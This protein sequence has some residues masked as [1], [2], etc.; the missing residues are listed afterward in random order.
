MTTFEDMSPTAEV[1]G[2]DEVTTKM[3]KMA[4]LVRRKPA[5]PSSSPSRVTKAPAISPRV[6]VVTRPSDYEALLAR[7]GTREQARFFLET[8]GRDIREA[9]ERD[10]WQRAVL[11]AISKAIPSK[12]RRAHVTRAD[13][14]RFYFEPDDVIACVGQDGLVANVAKYLT[15]QLVIG[16]NSDP[17]RNE[18][19]L[20]PHDAKNARSLIPAALADADNM[21]IEERTMVEAITDDGLRIVALNEIFAGHRT[22]QS[23]RYRLTYARSEERQSSSGIVVSTGTGATGW[24]RSIAMSRSKAPELPKPSDPQL[25]F[26]VREAFPSIA[27]GTNLVTGSVDAHD[28]LSIVSEM[29]EGGTLFGDG[30]ED[31]AID[32]RWGVCATIRPAAERLRLVL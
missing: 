30:I 19:I 20:V 18:G 25:V 12:M 27:T 14:S 10:A 32:F 1:M 7:H 17:S 5:S 8:R 4:K 26:F 15:G 24:A 9:E 31:D 22:H 6:V 2:K 29:N 13:L 11:D 21:D 28:P 16:V 23:A 3:A